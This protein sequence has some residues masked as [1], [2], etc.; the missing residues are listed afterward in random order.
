MKAKQPARQPA[1]PQDWRH[2][3]VGDQVIVDDTNGGL[4]KAEIESKALGSKAVWIHRYDTGTRHLFE[5]GDGVLLRP[6]QASEP[7]VP[8]RP[9]LQQETFE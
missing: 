3:K 6:L 9:M 8:R 5:Y 1:E 4:F 2:R 7:A